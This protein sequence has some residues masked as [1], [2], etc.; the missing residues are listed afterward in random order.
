MYI[1]LH[2]GVRHV[3]MDDGHFHRLL[4]IAFH[5]RSSTSLFCIDVFGDIEE[6]FVCFGLDT[7]VYGRL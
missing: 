6:R 2:G 3:C 1:G 7:Y 4:A 5:F